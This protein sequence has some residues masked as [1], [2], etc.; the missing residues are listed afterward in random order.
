MVHFVEGKI[1]RPIK[2]NVSS[3]YWILNESYSKP[4]VICDDIIL[5]FKR[6]NL[7]CCNYF[8]NQ[9]VNYTENEIPKTFKD[10][11]T[12]RNIGNAKALAHFTIISGK[13]IESWFT[14]FYCCSHHMFFFSSSN[15]KKYKP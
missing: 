6:D 14:E 10:W 8:C 2:S 1:F 3:T 4:I 9:D 13:Q 11:L 7:V 5:R 12:E 15:I